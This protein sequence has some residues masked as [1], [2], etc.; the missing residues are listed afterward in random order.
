MPSSAPAQSKTPIRLA[1]PIKDVPGV[2]PTRAKR[3]AKLQITQV[4]H[5][6]RHVPMRYE[7][8]QAESTIA[9]LAVGQIGSARGVIDYCGWV[10]MVE[11]G[12]GEAYI[13]LKAYPARG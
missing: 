10:P 5:L 6:I 11:K 8:E 9:Q 3:L 13:F 12:K 2:G 4:S 7:H 1:T